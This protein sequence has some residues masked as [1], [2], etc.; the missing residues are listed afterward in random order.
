MTVSAYFD[1]WPAATRGRV[2]EKT[3]RSYE[4]VL[5]LYVRPAIGEKRL[6]D[7]RPLDLQSLYSHM[8]AIKLKDKEAPQP[9]VIYGLGL[10]A[11]TVRYAHAVTFNAF[12][13]AVKWHMLARNPCE[14]AEPPRKVCKEMQALSP[15]EATRF[16]KAAAQ[17]RFGMLFELA[18]A[19]G[20]RPSEYLGLQWKDVDLETGIITVQRTLTWRKG[21]GWYFDEPKTPRSRRSIPLPA[22]TTRSL[23]EHKRRQAEAR[24]KAG[25]LIRAMILYSPQTTALPYFYAISSGV[26]SG[27]CSKRLSCP[28]R[29]GCMT[30]AIVALHFHSRRAFIRRWPAKD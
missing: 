25:R 24:M 8:Q 5:R 10:S 3:F 20:M 21:G 12:R 17:N 9:G 15:D 6:M 29:S 30:C 1:K 23:K 26:I 22:S 19:T 18:L 14:A 16:L 2:R 4:E 28:L 13:Q 11:R 7:V 27:L